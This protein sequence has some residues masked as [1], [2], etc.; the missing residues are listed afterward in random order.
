MTDA[1]CDTWRQEHRRWAVIAAPFLLTEDDDARIER[2]HIGWCAGGHSRCAL[3]SWRH[4]PGPP[5]V[6]RRGNLRLVDRQR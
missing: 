6:A 2:T 5:L 3:T 4:W 1:L